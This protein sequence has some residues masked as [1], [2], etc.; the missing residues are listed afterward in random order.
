MAVGF[1]EYA[2]WVSG[3][4]MLFRRYYFNQL[5]SVWFQILW[6]Q[7]VESSRATIGASRADLLPTMEV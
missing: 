4:S 5:L 7:G 2:W 6:V 3:L 1:G